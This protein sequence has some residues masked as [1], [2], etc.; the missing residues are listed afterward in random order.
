LDRNQAGR[1]LRDAQ[2]PQI[3]L[4]GIMRL[5]LNELTAASTF[6]DENGRRKKTLKAEIL[7]I[8]TSSSV[9]ARKIKKIRRIKGFL[10][11]YGL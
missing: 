6:R 4:R 11:F 5:A 7:R 8:V 2:V 1:K 9:R 10:K 3:F